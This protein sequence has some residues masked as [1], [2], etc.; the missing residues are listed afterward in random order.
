MWTG[1]GGLQ[2][3]HVSPAGSRRV[4]WSMWTF[5]GF[6]IQFFFTNDFEKK[7]IYITSIPKE[8]VKKLFS[9]KIYG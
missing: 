5:S 7:I 2:I 4:G 3:V 9:L 6:R 1:K 8:I